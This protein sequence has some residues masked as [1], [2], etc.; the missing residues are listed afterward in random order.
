MPKVF[1]TEDQR[2]AER[3]RKLRLC[4]GDRVA[5]A[6]QREDWKLM[7]M[8]HGLNM[9]HTSVAKIMDGQDVNLSTTKFL[10]ILDLAGLMLVDRRQDE[11]TANSR[12]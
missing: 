10:Q 4:I 6:K 9:A 7:D 1:L 5:R 3:Y 2:T 8:A 11:I 12:K